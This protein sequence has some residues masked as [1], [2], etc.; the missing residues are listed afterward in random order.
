MSS[1]R[2][3]TRQ[4]AARATAAAAASLADLSTGP[5]APELRF[6]TAPRPAALGDAIG[7]AVL[8]VACPLAS[9][10]GTVDGADLVLTQAADALI[11]ATGDPDW[12]MLVD[13]NGQP[14]ADMTVGPAPTAPEDPVYQVQLS[15]PT[16]YEGGY[17]R[18]APLVITG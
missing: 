10:A 14:C 3:S 15:Q 13:G 1:L 16:L 12:A 7:A 4:Q 11:T 6:Y 18:L 17:L 9:P 5:A 8:L 2:L